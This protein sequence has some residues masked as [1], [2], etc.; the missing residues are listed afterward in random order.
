MLFRYL[1]TFS[2]LFLFTNVVLAST[3]Y[4]C[5]YGDTSIFQDLPCAEDFDY[6]IEEI[7]TFDGWKYGMNI[8][9]F[10]EASKL[11]KLPISPGQTLLTSQFNEKLLNSNPDTR[12]Y[13]YSSVIV[14]KRTKVTLFFT[15]RT[16][17]LYKIKASLIVAQLPTEEKQ[18][19][20]TSLVN[21]L[22]LKYGTYLESRNY[23]KSS[24]LLAK[25]ILNE[26]VGTEKLWGANSD[27]IVSLAGNSPS[28]Q[29]YELTYKY[30]PLLK[31]SISETTQEIRESTEKAMI[32][33]ADKF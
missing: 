30:I 10:K 1:I 33:D 22:T 15:Q 9:A 4:T 8:L 27:N 31:Q 24:N 12:I 6:G 7:D 14:G 11:R 21:Q 17:K 20:Y 23:P 16:Q 18:Y 32:R 26:L 29:S 2:T 5:K 13:A 19:F 28:S 25:L 3:I